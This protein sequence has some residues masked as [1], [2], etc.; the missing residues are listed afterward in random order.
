[1]KKVFIP[2]IGVAIFIVAVGL[3]TKNVQRGKF[4]NIFSKPSITSEKKNEVKIGNA[5]IAVDIADTDEER[6]KGLGGRTSLSEGSGMLFIMPQENS[7]PGF[8]MKDMI[9]P[10]DMIWIN[11]GKISKIDKN[12]QPPSSGTPDSELTV[13]RSNAPTDYVLEVPAGSSDK[14]GFKEGDTLEIKI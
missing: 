10:I 11:D 1:M 4:L 12:I 7:N 13:Y 9:I 3:L 5:A 6:K 14:N 2:I 8:W